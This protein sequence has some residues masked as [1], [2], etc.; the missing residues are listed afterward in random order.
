MSGIAVPFTILVIHLS[1]G[2]ALLAVRYVVHRLTDTSISS[3]G[4]TSCGSPFVAHATSHLILRLHVAV[5]Q[6]HP[7]GMRFQ[8]GKSLQQSRVK[9]LWPSTLAFCNTEHSRFF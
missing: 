8:Y 1:H 5:G 2:H 4:P 3:A 9:L 6:S 7:R